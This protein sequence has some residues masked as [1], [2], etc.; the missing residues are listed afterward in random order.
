MQHLAHKLTALLALLLFSGAAAAQ[1]ASTPEMADAMRANGK[2]YVVVA[3]LA[4]VFVGIVVYLVML[5]RKI[6]RIEK[7]M[8]E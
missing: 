3:V 8:D 4:A 6:G 2:I 7:G 5:D 1:Q